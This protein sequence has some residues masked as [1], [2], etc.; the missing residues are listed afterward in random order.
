MAS[1]ETDKDS[2][3]F[4]LTVLQTAAR[5]PIDAEMWA[6]DYEYDVQDNES[7]VTVYESLPPDR[8]A[9]SPGESIDTLSID[10]IEKMLDERDRQRTSLDQADQAESQS[11][12]IAQDEWSQ[13][14]Q[15]LDDG[16]ELAG[17]YWAVVR[18]K[19]AT[20][21]A[22][23]GDDVESPLTY[24]P[25]TVAEFDLQTAFA[26]ADGG[27][28]AIEEVYRRHT[29]SDPGTQIH[30]SSIFSQSGADEAI[31]VDGAAV[32]SAVLNREIRSLEASA[33]RLRKSKADIADETNVTKERGRRL[34]DDKNSWD[35]DAEEATLMA[36][37]FAAELAKS[38]GQL[39][40]TEQAILALGAELRTTVGRLVERI[41][42]VAPAPDQ[43]P[44][45]GTP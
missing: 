40:A 29:L 26:L 12:A 18:F 42:A 38:R 22:E 11:R 2:K 14:R 20:T 43:P 41:D 45:A 30:G 39:A 44:A 24:E 8:W 9:A 3:C 28:A 21:V 37:S 31:L 13:I 10:E 36:S 34:A 32:L 23:A 33:E 4:V 17:S 35:R 19:E 6:S 16:T 5:D 15:R 27:K 1:S 25:D 7:G